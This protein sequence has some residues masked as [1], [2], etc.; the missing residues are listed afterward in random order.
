MKASLI[1]L[2][3]LGLSCA[4][5]GGLP[6]K[7]GQYTETIQENGLDRT[8]ILKIP[9]SYDGKASLPLVL[10]FH[11]WTGDAQDIEGATGFGDKADKE[12]F[13]LAIPNGTEGIGSE[14]G[15]NCGFLNLGRKRPT[16]PNFLDA[17]KIVS[18]GPSPNIE[19]P[20]YLTG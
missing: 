2:A 6:T 4:H 9:K 12:G 17:L 16:Q 10:L 13:I 11:G 15:W 1:P 20:R 8:Y 18:D 3:F 5:Q 7:P 14:R 19:A